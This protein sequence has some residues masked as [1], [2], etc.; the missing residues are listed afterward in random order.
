MLTCVS[1][2]PYAQDR[3]PMGEPPSFE[4]MDTNGDGELQ[5]DE[6]RGPLADQF[7]QL[8]T[9]NSGGLSAQE[10]PEPPKPRQ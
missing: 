9:D 5:M 3:P 6:L 8:D 7:D 1:L 10:I 4:E 2:Q